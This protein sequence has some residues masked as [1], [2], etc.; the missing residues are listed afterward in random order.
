MSLLRPVSPM[1]KLMMVLCCLWFEVKY[2]LVLH[3]FPSGYG[4]KLALPN[5]AAGLRALFFP[6]PWFWSIRGVLLQA[7]I[8]PKWLNGLVWVPYSFQSDSNSTNKQQPT[9]T[10]YSPW[11]FVWKLTMLLG[12]FTFKMLVVSSSTAEYCICMYCTIVSAN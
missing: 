2:R 11:V 7:G 9:Y 6:N 5:S 8:W 12:R 3:S 10:V 4:T 1:R